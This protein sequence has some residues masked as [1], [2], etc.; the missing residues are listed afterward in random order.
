MTPP[1][2]GLPF[3]TEEWYRYYE[4]HTHQI[5]SDILTQEIDF[6]STERDLKS[7]MEGQFKSSLHQ[8]FQRVIE[9]YHQLIQHQMLEL[10]QV[11]IE[12]RDLMDYWETDSDSQSTPASS[13]SHEN[14]DSKS[15]DEEELI[16]QYLQTFG[17]KE[18]VDTDTEYCLCP[19]CRFLSI[20][21]LLHLSLHLNPC[22]DTVDCSCMKCNMKHSIRLGKVGSEFESS[23]VSRLLSSE[24][25]PSPTDDHDCLY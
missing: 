12:M 8:L 10:N 4:S 21:E 23:T 1:P 13:S 15:E 2:P 18:T 20:H 16:E 9:P 24:M 22:R 14:P 7:W 17:I 6:P 3:Q 25:D 5:V 11:K 19:E